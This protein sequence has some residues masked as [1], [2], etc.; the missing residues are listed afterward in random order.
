[1]TRSTGERLYRAC[2]RCRQRKTKCDLTVELTEESKYTNEYTHRPCSKCAAEGQQCIPAASRRGGDY[3]RFRIRKNLPQQR[4]SSE[5]NDPEKPYLDNNLSRPA[6]ARDGPSQSIGGVQNPLEALQILAQTASSE[7]TMGRTNI[8]IAG[9]LEHNSPRANCAGTQNGIMSNLAEDNPTSAAISWAAETFLLTAVLTIATKDRVGLEALHSRILGYMENLLL[10]VVLGAT[11][12]RHVGSV[13]GL[14]LLAEWVPHVS[15]GACTQYDTVNGRPSG[16][17]QVPDEDSAAWNLVGL[18]VRQAYLLHLESYSFRGE[19]RDETTSM[20]YRKRLAWF[21]TY[22]ADRQISI[23]MGQAFWCRGP[24]LSA[25]FTVDDYPSLRP[26]TQGGVDHASFVQAQ[27]ELTTIFG[28]VHDILY[29]SK[30]RTVQL[31]LMGDYAKY[32]DDSSKALVMWKETWGSV[33]LPPHL[34]CL[35]ILQFEYLRLYINAFAFQAVLYRS[36][37]NITGDLG[38]TSYFP[39]SVMATPDGRHI[40]L[41]IDAAK[42]VLKG[43]MERLNPT[44]HLRYLPVRFYLYEIHASV[45][46]FKALSVGAL[47][48]G[49]HQSCSVLVRQFIS[50]LKSAATC[51]SHIA[52]RYGRLLTNL[53]FQGQLT[54]ED[55]NDPVQTNVSTQATHTGSSATLRDQM[56]P[57][58]ANRVLSEN[59]VSHPLI[60]DAFHSPS[61]TSPA[62]LTEP[63]DCPNV[64]LSNLPFLR[65]GFPD[66]EESEVGQLLMD[67]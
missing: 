11:S 13:E 39:Y 49:E 31:M 67:L 20:F 35:L 54:P 14:L 32:L 62:D 64:F 17:I 2:V 6:G 15:S 36:S 4:D 66:L 28:N 52:S 27:V 16:H 9:E 42:N 26:Q 48:S 8:N 53:W 3:S 60:T 24:G 46:L 61:E 38:K 37:R 34:G 25:R 58:H 51:P 21:F 50:M 56:T 5:V 40:Y 19:A 55:V 47:T 30:T 41:A 43:L 65:G 12:V 1:M 59:T 57:N 18:A 45:F 22:L 44:K 63:F 33:D 10:R 23:Q 7:R 29:A